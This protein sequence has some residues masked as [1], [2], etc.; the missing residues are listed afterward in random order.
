[1]KKT[2]QK[3]SKDSFFLVALSL[4]CLSFLVGMVFNYNYTIWSN[5][6]EMHYL[7][8]T[9]SIIKDRDLSLRNNYENKD[10]F[11]HH[12]NL[13][14]PH[15]IKDLN[16]NWRSFHGVLTS[17]L[18]VPGYLVKGLRGARSIILLINFLFALALVWTLKLSKLNVTISIFTVSFFLLQ[19]VILF[20]SNAIY[21]NLISGFLGTFITT[22]LLYYSIKKFDKNNVKFVIL[23]SILGGFLGYL[24]TKMFLLGLIILFNFFLVSSDIY[25]NIYNYFTKSTKSNPSLKQI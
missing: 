2:I 10:Y 8:T 24:H 19:P 21:P 14:S 18:A 15:I 3:L 4:L 6:D 16:G 17:V 22:L 23:S 20:F 5:G 25:Q 1:M 9:Q 11:E 13:E 7:T 12:A